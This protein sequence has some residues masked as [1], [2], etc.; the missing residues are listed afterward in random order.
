MDS[1]ASP[2]TESKDLLLAYATDLPSVNPVERW[3]RA[4]PST[5]HERA[6]VDYASYN[7]NFVLVVTSSCC[8]P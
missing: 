5:P 2:F 1:L 3:Q 7:G 4:G 6:L 8:I